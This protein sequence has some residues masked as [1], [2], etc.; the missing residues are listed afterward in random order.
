MGAVA[1]IL[2]AAETKQAADPAAMAERLSELQERVSALP[3]STGSLGELSK[4]APTAEQ[5]SRRNALKWLAVTGAGAV[6]V[7]AILRALKAGHERRRRERFIE[8]IDP[9]AGMPGREITIPLP[10][11]AKTSSAKE[12]GILVPALA[13]AAAAPA[14][15]RAAGSGVGNI[16]ERLK[17]GTRRG[18]SHL[19]ASTGSPWDEPWFLPAA[20]VAGLGG[21]YLG[22]SKLDK[23][24]EA[25]REARSGRETAKARK[26]FEEALRAQYTQSELLEQAGKKQPKLK[27]PDEGGFKFAGAMGMVADAFAQAHVSGELAEQF[28]SMEKSA[29][30]GLEPPRGF[31]WHSFKG[32]GRKALG[33]YLAALALLTAAGTGAGYSFVKSREV[34]RR[35]H[36]IAK[37]VMR[38]R[39]LTTPP[40][41]TVEPA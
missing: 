5:E 38:R 30:G 22:Y 12:A 40:T 34:K 29:Q 15:A 28:A 33:V 31:G 25:R 3:T 9:Y 8:D 4:V 39:A 27:A 10:H 26:E 18:V 19:F 16:W 23:L 24:L 17:G 14:A 20:I 6:G 21:G 2:K 7:G 32:S 37:D 1:K 41:I 13:A 11:M 36:D 35:K